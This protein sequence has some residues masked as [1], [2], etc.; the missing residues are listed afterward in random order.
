MTLDHIL[1]QVVP[2]SILKRALNTNRIG[3]AYLFSGAEGLGKET[4]ARAMAH[5]LTK[6]G[7]PLSEIHILDGDETI[8][9]GDVRE[10]HRKAA[11]VPAGYSIWIILE[12]K[13]MSVEASNAFLKILEEPPKGTYFFLTTTQVQALLPTIIS[14]CQ[15]LPF[16][17]IAE[18]DI[19]RWLANQEDLSVGDA[20]VQSIARLAHGSL[21]KAWAYWKGSLL[22]ERAVLVGK[23]MDVPKSSY[24]QV[25]GLSQTWPEDRKKVLGE[26]ELFLEWF[27]DLLIIKNDIGLPLYNPGYKRELGEISAFYTNQDLIMIM[28]QIMETEKA[29]AGNGRIR[30]Y[31][32][33]LL[34]LMKE[35]ALT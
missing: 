35:G 16:R 28:E 29:I 19:A 15:H 12:V 32:G 7:G 23:L 13:R 5:E 9:I 4:V 34:L 25:L 2:V 21:G 6:L 11:L 1:G 20:K 3:H 27:R 14:R 26:L 33:Y 31:L 10:L 24:S 8:K 17:R 22:D 18:E 30:F